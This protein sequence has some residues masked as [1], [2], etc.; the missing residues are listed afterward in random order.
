MVTISNVLRRQCQT[1]HVFRS[2]ATTLLLILRQTT[3]QVSNYYHYNLFDLNLAK[4]ASGAPRR[5]PTPEQSRRDVWTETSRYSGSSQYPGSGVISLVRNSVDGG[6]KATASANVGKQA[7]N[8][9]RTDA[10]SD[11]MHSETVKAHSN[12]SAA[13][14]QPS[15]G[16]RYTQY[17]HPKY[18]I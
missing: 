3:V 16:I 18:P 11:Q 6:T 12:V 17:Q 1:R 9:A 7:Y 13:T 2:V 4:V 8:V 10:T 15:P 14:T 5:S